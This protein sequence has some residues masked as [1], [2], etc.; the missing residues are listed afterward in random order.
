MNRRARR[1]AE[2][3]ARHP[4]RPARL[5][6]PHWISPASSHSF[7]LPMSAG[8]AGLIAPLLDLVEVAPVGVE[9][10]VGFFVGPVVRHP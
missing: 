9:R 6:P 7:V 4:G 2:A 3:R 10:I 8:Q 1:A 5:S